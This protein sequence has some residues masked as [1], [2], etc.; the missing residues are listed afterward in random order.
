MSR[1]K[2]IGCRD[3]ETI[4]NYLKQNSYSTTKDETLADLLGKDAGSRG[5]QDLL[6]Y[7][8]NDGILT[9]DKTSRPFRYRLKD[10]FYVVDVLSSGDA[11]E[12]EYALDSVNENFTVDTQNLMKRIFE[13]RSSVIGKISQHEDIADERLQQHFNDLLEA[14]EKRLYVKLTLKY[15]TTKVFNEVRCLKLIFTD[16]NWYIFFD[17]IDEK[18][19]RKARFGRIS[20]IKEIKFLKDSKYSNKNSFQEQELYMY[21]DF[22]KSI[23]NAM[24]LHGQPKFK[25]TIKAMPRV[26]QYFDQGMK[27]FFNSQLY[28]KKESDGSVIFTVEYTQPLELM[29]FVQKWMPDLVIVEPQVL[30]DYYRENLKVMLER[31]KN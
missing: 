28:V 19:G 21:D 25:A 1:I 16:N 14:V 11:L 2:D 12:M 24:T 7:L 22:Y 5:F 17:Y 13:T 23:Q 20:F 4:V 18:L 30:Q 15:P 3:K 10:K 27:K 9:L 8:E 26:G 6:N 29:P 31:Q